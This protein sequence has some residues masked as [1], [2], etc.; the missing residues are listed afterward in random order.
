MNNYPN[1]IIIV[2]QVQVYFKEK[3]NQI[4]FI[5]YV[6]GDDSSRMSF[7]STSSKES[8]SVA[9]PINT[10]NQSNGIVLHSTLSEPGKTNTIF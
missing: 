9:A 4:L 1:L 3:S 10:T 2:Y 5:F 7:S 8:S 6:L